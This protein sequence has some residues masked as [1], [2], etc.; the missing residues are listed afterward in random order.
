MGI[1]AHF[2]AFDPRVCTTPPT[3]DQLVKSG[4]VDHELQ[5]L[6]E[7][8]R[9]LKEIASPLGDNKRWYDNLAGDFAWSCAREHVAPEDRSPLDH[10]FSHLFWHGAADGRC[11][12]GREP[13]VVAEN[14]EVYD[15]A[16]LE[17]ILSLER[18][19][20]VVEPALAIEFNGDPPKTERL[21]RPWI[22]D[23]DNFCDLALMWQHL[24]R[25][26]TKAGP[27]WS[28]LQWLSP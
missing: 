14:E 24:I 27:G 11:P 9:W 2:F 25:R 22:Y 4:A 23:F 15:S 10:W 12:C 21:D 18:P 6:G 8:A 28:L 1:T 5:V 26:A 20:W 17:H 16:L 19:L 3:I 13:A 7:A